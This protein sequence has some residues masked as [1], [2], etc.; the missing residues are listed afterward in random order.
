MI[1]ITSY[2]AYIPMFRLSR[3]ELGRAWGRGSITGEKAVANS[4]EDSLTMAVE[5][6]RDCLRGQQ[7]NTVDGLYFATTTSPYLEK[8]SASII[9]AAAD[10]RK[11]IQTIDFTN[12]LRGG[13]SAL[14]AALDAVKAESARSVM[15]TAGDCRVPAPESEMESLVG[16][17]A[18]ALLVGDSNVVVEL[19]DRYSLSSELLDVWRRPSDRFYR[20]WEDRYVLGNYKKIMIQTITTMLQRNSLSAKDVSKVAYYAPDPRRHQEIARQLGLDYKSQVQEPLFSQVGNTGAAFAMMMLVAALEEAKPGDRILFASYGDGCDA[21]LLRV[22]EGIEAAR[23][24]RGIRGHLASKMMLSNYEKYV[25]F[26]G[27]M[28]REAL[29]YGIDQSSLTYYQRES[30]QVLSLHGAR[31]RNCNEVHYPIQRVCPWCQAK[32]DYEEVGFSDKRG[33]VFTYCMDERAW[34]A[35][36]PLV[37]CIVDMEG[38][39]RLYSTMTDRIPETVDI[40]MTVELTFRRVYEAA[41]FI[42]YYWKVRQVRD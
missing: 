16:D 2:G 28:E 30:S 32:D 7:R 20:T 36:L 6:V 1:G 10:L 22:T 18:A 15:V 40:D 12:S 25:R 26:R 24:H 31:C 38:G 29:H 19:E 9:A 17:G 39:G 4:D 5:A 23:E 11:D 8:Q 14:W 21:F 33:K 37:T 27:L 34:V 35:D 3:E 13:T 41:G 42:H